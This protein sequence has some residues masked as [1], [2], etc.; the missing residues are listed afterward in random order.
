MAG[1]NMVIA[2]SGG[3]SAVINASLAGA[4]S[5]AMASEE[6][7]RIYGAVNGL[8]GFLERRLIDI[9]E[10]IRST[11]DLDL[12]IHTPSHALGT[13]RYKLPAGQPAV[14]DDVLAILQEYNAGYFF[15]IGGND[16][17]D[18]ISRLAAYFKEKGSDIK[19]VGIPKTI[20][21]DLAVTDHSPGFG[22]AAKFVAMVTAEVHLDTIVYPI[23]AV[24]IL[25]IMGR[26]AGWLTAASAL[27][28]RS[29]IAAPHLIY[30]PEVDFDPD[31]FI[32]DVAAL[33]ETE[34]QIV[35]AISE[36]IRLADG[37]YIAETGAAEDM[38]G[39]KTLGGA[40]TALEAMIKRE[41]KLD[42]LKIRAIQ[43]STLQ[44]SA[45]HIASATDQA[46]AFQCGYRAVEAA[47]KGISGVMISI[48]R[49]SNDPYLVYYQESP[50]V[51]IAN[52]EQKVP[53]EWITPDG[54]DVT[55]EA[56]DYLLPLIRGE[57]TERMSEGLPVFFR[58]DWSKLVT[59]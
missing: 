44:R 8:Q 27:A 50:L 49:A 24:T 13:A 7:D 55:Q 52:V 36:G 46:E 33:L 48:Q 21:N 57:A 19:A 25:E 3:P 39:H 59:P 47:L 40:A 14:F 56:I 22:S 31:A 10:Q 35:I 2:Q 9:T 38:F 41:I 51:G 43:L 28:R 17:M 45:A 32:A 37:S 11:D 5:R 12:L 1:R 23:P 34:K 15:F 16:S 26:N 42:K 4:I 58:F 53:L 54:K 18:S 6:I 29:G 20:D 30:L